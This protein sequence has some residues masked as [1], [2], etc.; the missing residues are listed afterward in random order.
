MNLLHRII[1]IF[2]AKL[3]SEEAGSGEF[4]WDYEPSNTADSVF[5]SNQQPPKPNIDPII[6][7][8]YA[9]LEVAYG[10]DLQ[11]VTESWKRLLRKYHPDLFSNDPE[12][13]AIANQLVQ[14]LNHS[15][16][17]LKKYLSK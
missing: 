3:A 6:A 17:E 10:A 5:N 14:E 8:Y 4:Q 7:S 11:T 1:N 15:Y 12:K 13:Q 16:T 2:R 9:H